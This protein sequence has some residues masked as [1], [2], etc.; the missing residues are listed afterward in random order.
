MEMKLAIKHPQ[1]QQ[2]EG[3]FRARWA[4]KRK[5]I[6]EADEGIH[7]LSENCSFHD[8]QLDGTQSVDEVSLQ[9]AVSGPVLAGA[10]ADLL[11]QHLANTTV[12]RFHRKMPWEAWPFDMIFGEAFGPSGSND[13]TFRTHRGVF[14]DFGPQRVVSTAVQHVSLARS[15]CIYTSAV[16]CATD[17]DVKESEAKRHEQAVRKMCIVL[18]Q[19]G[20]HS[21]LPDFHSDGVGSATEMD[22][23]S[24]T[25]AASL[26]LKASLTVLKR[27]G[28][29]L[30]F[31]HWHGQAYDHP[32]VPLREA[33]VCNYLRWLR[34]TGAA[35]TRAAGFVSALRFLH[36]M[37]AVEG[38]ST[39][40]VSKGICGLADQGRS[41]ICRE[42]APQASAGA[43]SV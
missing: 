12:D 7:V 9:P 27:A 2:R 32:A 14:R 5:F 25:V 26:G 33:D 21:N 16:T 39:C 24:E 19:C 29:I 15:D 40:I 34:Q 8:E 4:R 23:L 17:S 36:F 11:E 31:F 42:T 30:Q 41:A 3:G 18:L 13:L 10:N 35:P 22:L 43:Q 1:I 28:S 6:G 20:P 38:C 37:F